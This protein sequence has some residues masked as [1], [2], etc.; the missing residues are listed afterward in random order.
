MVTWQILVL[1]HMQNRFGHG[2]T[3]GNKELDIE[4]NVAR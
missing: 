1:L 3:A 4:M 2:W